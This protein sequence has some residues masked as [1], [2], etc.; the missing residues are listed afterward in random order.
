[1]AEL[2]G[3]IERIRAFNEAR[4]WAQF[5]SPKNLSMS[6]MI[7]A[8]ELAE[9]FQWLTEEESRSLSAEKLVQ[10]G[11]EIGDVLIYLL[12]VADKLGI[13]PVEVATRKMDINEEKYPVDKA[14]G[15]ADKYTEL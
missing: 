2:S 6:L 8:A 1:M 13:D 15:S 7:E 12:N 14:R 10:A 3:L 11:E 4:D 9:I 5:H